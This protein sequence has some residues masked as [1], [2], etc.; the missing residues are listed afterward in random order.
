MKKKNK[1]LILVSILMIIC[2][3]LT[4]YFLRKKKLD[5]INNYTDTSINLI[6]EGDFKSAESYF[7]KTLELDKNNKKILEL[8]ATIQ[9]FEELQTLYNDEKYEDATK[10]IP[11]ISQ[12]EFYY[13]IEKEVSMINNDI[14]ARIKLLD[15]FQNAESQF[16][17]KNYYEAD[18]LIKEVLSMDNYD[19]IQEQA[20]VLASEISFRIQLLDE[21]D[22]L[23]SKIKNFLNSNS[24]DVALDLVN[25][26]DTNH[27]PDTYIKKL[28][29]FKTQISASKKKYDDENRLITASEAEEMV[30]SYLELW[31]KPHFIDTSDLETQGGTYDEIKGLTGYRVEPRY[32]GYDDN[33]STSLGFYFVDAKTKHIYKLDVTYAKY[34]RIK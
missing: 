33:H 11:D 19:L 12:M 3:S 27:L 18:R 28:S 7:E 24:Y 25:R 22:S 26:Y 13:L 32:T 14:T 10:L 31:D 23:D 4:F 2:I 29:D 17:E 1:I 20:D 16:E 8:K 5:T 30:K 6:I 34:H 9:A 15:T 21:I